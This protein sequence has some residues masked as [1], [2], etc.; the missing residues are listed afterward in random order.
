MLAY[1]YTTLSHSLIHPHTLTSSL[2][3]TLTHTQESNQNPY[4]ADS[5]SFRPSKIVPSDYDDVLSHYT[6]K[7]YRVIGCATRHIP[8]LSWVRAQKMSRADAEHDLDFVGFIIFENKIKPSTPAVLAELGY[9]RIP[10]TMVTG[11]NILTAISVGRLCGL[12]DPLAHCYVPH[13]VEGG[14][15]D[16]KAVLAWESIDDAA[17]KLDSQTLLVGDGPRFFFLFCRLC[18]LFGQSPLG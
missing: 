6:H 14:A 2:F 4:N 10:T 9:A 17:L 15:G 5:P 16:P 8:K 18:S 13:F 1:S 7:G 3:L 11:D 12:V